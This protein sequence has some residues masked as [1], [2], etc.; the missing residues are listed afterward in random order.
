M[1]AT[2][3]RAIPLADSS[4]PQINPQFN[5]LNAWRQCP[6]CK[7][8]YRA[9]DMGAVPVASDV[10]VVLI[11]VCR[12][13]HHK[14]LSSARFRQIIEDNILAKFAPALDNLAGAK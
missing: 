7:G 12:V 2:A 10:A 5:P 11:P 4:V 9:G 14:A 8:I 1:R 13:C 6:G 3:G